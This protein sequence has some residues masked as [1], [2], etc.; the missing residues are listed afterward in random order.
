MDQ[1][2]TPNTVVMPM[3]LLQAITQYLSTR[4]YSEVAGMIRGIEQ[5]ARALPQ[6]DTESPAPGAPTGD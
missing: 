5:T 4:P 6:P 1:T 3:N 2:T